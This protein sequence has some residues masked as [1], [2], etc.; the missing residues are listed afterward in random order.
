MQVFLAIDFTK[1]MKI[2]LVPY[3]NFVKAC[4]NEN[5]LNPIL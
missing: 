3:K 4:V 2:L 1:C 5:M